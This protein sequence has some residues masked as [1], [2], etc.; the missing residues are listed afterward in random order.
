MYTRSA[1]ILLSDTYFAGFL[2]SDTDA[3]LMYE[4][5]A[6]LLLPETYLAFFLLSSS[7]LVLC[8]HVLLE[9]C[10]QAQVSLLRCVLTQILV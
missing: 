1:R 10:F 8:A 9:L 4:R 5:S 2:R 7:N 3:G 6:R